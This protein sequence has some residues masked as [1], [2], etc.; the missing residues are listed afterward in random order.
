[1]VERAQATVQRTGGSCASKVT[2]L[3]LLVNGWQ[4]GPFCGPRVT[5]GSQKTGCANRSLH[6]WT[7]GESTPSAALGGPVRSIPGR[8]G[9]RVAR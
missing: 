7:I 3:P 9:H 8:G 1:M 6:I 2:L 5:S 4:T